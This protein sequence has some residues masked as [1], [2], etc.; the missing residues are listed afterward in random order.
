M[1]WFTLHNILRQMDATLSWMLDRRL[2]LNVEKTVDILFGCGN[3][4]RK[5]RLIIGNRPIDWSTKANISCRF[6]RLDS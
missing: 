5:N 1:F 6:L 2:Q 3:F 4:E